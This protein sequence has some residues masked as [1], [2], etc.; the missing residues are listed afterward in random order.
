MLSQIE[1]CQLFDDLGT[2][3]DG[4]RIVTQA[5]E[6]SPVRNVK[7]TNSNVVTCF[8]SNKM[9]RSI[10]TESMRVEYPAVVFYE[11]DES[12]LEYYTQPC[13]LEIELVDKSTSSIKKCTHYPDILII[14]KDKIVLEEWKYEKEFERLALKIPYRYEKLNERWR[15]TQIEE[16]L[17]EIGICYQLRCAEEHPLQY[18]KNISFIADYTRPGYMSLCQEAIDKL[19]SIF[20]WSPVIA[21]KDVVA[22]LE[23]NGLESDMLYKAIA[24]GLVVFDMFNDDISST[25]RALLYRDHVAMEFYKI[26]KENDEKDVLPVLN[27]SVNS[28]LVYDGIEYK[29]D[30]LG[31]ESIILSSNGYSRKVDLDI[32]EKGFR[33]GDI[34]TLG[35]PIKDDINNESECLTSEEMS[36]ALAR[37]KLVEESDNGISCESVSLRTMQRYRQ[38]MRDSGDNLQKQNYALVPEHRHKGNRNVKINQQIIEAIQL[39][40][41]NRFNNPKAITKKKAYKNFLNHCY[42]HGLI[43]CSCKTF[44]KHLDNYA[45]IKKRK[46]T[47]FEY[48]IKPL[49]SYLYWDEPMHGFRPFECVH[50]DHTQLDILLRGPKDTSVLGRAWLTLSVDAESRNVLG[51]YISYDAPSYRSCMMVLRDIVRRHGRL[52]EMIVVD[53]GKEFKSASFMQLADFYRVSI[54]YRPKG[55]PRYGSVVERLFG[56]INKQLIHNMEGNTK[57]MQHVRMVTKAV[58]PEN[59]VYWTLPALHNALNYFFETLYGCEPHPAHGETPVSYFNKRMA[60]T[61]MRRNRMIKFDKNFLIMTCP[62]VDRGGIR[63]VDSQRGIKNNKVFYWCNEL[64]HESGK[65][66]EVRFDP[67][68]IRFVYVKISKLWHRCTSKLIFPLRSF[69]AVELRYALSEFKN[70]RISKGPISQERLAEWLSVFDCDSH[71]SRLRKQQDEAAYVYNKLGIGVVENDL[72]R[73]IEANAKSNIMLAEE[74]HSCENDFDNQ[75]ENIEIYE[76]FS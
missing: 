70:N 71:D 3:P 59:F 61:G 63:T 8:A 74:H 24:E 26:D 45:S 57:I 12:V 46:G 64:I 1:L 25:D 10:P 34:Y 31:Q 30:L 48:H 29:I 55:K 68:D 9:D 15:S 69:T 50:I 44:N 11:H 43:P 23:V 52:P 51:F 47:R 7:S 38:I 33:N 58:R 75:V 39:V 65:Q 56:T 73:D 36:V 76:R 22:A 60:E 28:E 2:P 18:L 17:A 40:A 27:L 35:V 66:V 67:W 21:L 72:T 6:R 37:R 54:R 4:R 41:N 19:R 14:Y 49:E 20:E 13:K 53:N 42:E 5:R 16:Y 32:I 62:Q